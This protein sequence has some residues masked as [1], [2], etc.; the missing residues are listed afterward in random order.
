M[1]PGRDKLK[2]MTESLGQLH[3]RLDR[4]EERNAISFQDIK[5]DLKDTRME[6]LAAIRAMPASLEA[7]T[8]AHAQ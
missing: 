8:P 1:D 2:R 5:A 4:S 7:A 6:L 3:E